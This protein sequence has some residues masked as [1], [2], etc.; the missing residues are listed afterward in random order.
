MNI[1]LLNIHAYWDFQDLAY[2][3]YKVIMSRQVYPYL[4][5]FNTK[6]TDRVLSESWIKQTEEIIGP[7]KT[8]AKAEELLYRLRGIVTTTN[9]YLALYQEKKNVSSVLEHCSFK[10]ADIQFKVVISSE[11]EKVEINLPEDYVMALKEAYRLAMA[12]CQGDYEAFVSFL[13][14]YSDTPY[15]KNYLQTCFRH[16]EE[17][18]RSSTAEQSYSFELY[19]KLF[20]KETS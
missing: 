9:Y 3:A 13:D 10:P 17:F 6:D 15:D 14:E 8:N 11:D 5:I 18:P 4:S 7:M 16:L 1:H 12:L 20:L 2:N 19:E